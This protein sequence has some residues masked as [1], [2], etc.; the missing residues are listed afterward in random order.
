MRKRVL[1]SVLLSVALTVT[2]FGQGEN[3]FI[4][5]S[6]WKEQP[7]IEKI[8]A[9]IEK[10]NAIAE[11]DGHHFDGTTWAILEGLPDET[12][13][14][15]LDQE[16]NGVNK[17]THDQRTYVFWAAYKG[18]YDLMLEL[19]ERGARMD[20]EDQFGY[21]VLTFSAVTGQLDT[22]IYDLCAKHGAEIAQ[23]TNKSGANV[24]LMLSPFIKHKVQLDYFLSKGLSISSVDDSGNN[25]FCYA[26]SSGNE[27]MAQKAIDAGL[28]VNANNGAAAYFAAKGLRS[29]KNNKSTFQLLKEQGVS[30]AHLDADNNNLLHVLAQNKNVGD[31]FTYLVQQGLNINAR[32]S[33]NQTPLLIAA[34]WADETT[35][36]QIVRIGGLT[37]LVDEEGNS[38]LHLSVKNKNEGAVVYLL[39]GMKTMINVPNEEGMTPLLSLA[40]KTNS[41]S[42]LRLYVEH[43]ANISDKT[44]FGETVY[45][46]ATENELLA[47]YHDELTFLNDEN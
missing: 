18:R 29:H 44:P 24:L 30:F 43:G 17:L 20:I 3:V 32:N 38:A 10:G 47:G 11:L 4:N 5:R 23:E 6:Y 27:F 12:I 7:S 40:M 21:S 39:K 26:A 33:K 15:L 1:L 36:K 19:I 42:R 9:D 28:N 16:G 34:D 35:I 8:K 14:F 37:D 45:Q 22:R 25:I 46:L 2:T 41:V 13:S 31:A